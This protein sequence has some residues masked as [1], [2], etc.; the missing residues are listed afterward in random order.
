MHPNRFIAARGFDCKVDLH[1]L[2]GRTKIAHGKATAQAQK[3]KSNGVKVKIKKSKVK[4]KVSVNKRHI[5][6]PPKTH[7]TSCLFLP[8][9]EPQKL[10]SFFCFHSFA[11]LRSRRQQ[12]LVSQIARWT[13]F[14][15]LCERALGIVD[16]FMASLSM[17]YGF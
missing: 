11:I 8:F 10:F 5:I 17:W 15:V 6:P 12:D 7:L 14:W 2:H 1:S 9:G 4:V 16:M 13:P 3:S